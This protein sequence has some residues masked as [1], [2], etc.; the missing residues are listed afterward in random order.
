MSVVAL[1]SQTKSLNPAFERSVLTKQRSSAVIKN[2]YRQASKLTRQ[3]TERTLE[4]VS[5][6][7]IRMEEAEECAG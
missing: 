4:Q 1:S 6:I 2:N 7:H 5:D 3:M